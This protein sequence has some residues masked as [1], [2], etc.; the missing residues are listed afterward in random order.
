MPAARTRARRGLRAAAILLGLLLGAV[1]RSMAAQSMDLPVETQI[2]LFL[3]LL[4]FDRNLPTEPGTQLVIAIVFQGGNRESSAAR[5][6]AT[7]E[8]LK[9]GQLMPGLTARIVDIDLERDRDVAA[10]LVTQGVVAMY[11]SPL[12]AV[13]IHA[14]TRITR[15]AQVRSFSGVTRY[16]TQGIGLGATMRGDLPQI[17]VNLPATR[18]EGADFS[19]QLLKLARVIN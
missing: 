3:K 15:A 2:P 5:R 9:A 14:L 13:D 16:V 8:L 7:V 10:I 1:V 6:Q 12:R 18:E 17:I 11:I 19:A 4:T